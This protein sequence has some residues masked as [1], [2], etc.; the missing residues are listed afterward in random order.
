MERPFGSESRIGRMVG[1]LMGRLAPPA[2][3]VPFR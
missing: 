3:Q 2:L 1:D